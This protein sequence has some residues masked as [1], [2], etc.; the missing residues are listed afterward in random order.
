MQNRVT[1]K[2]LAHFSRNF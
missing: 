2:F 1:Q